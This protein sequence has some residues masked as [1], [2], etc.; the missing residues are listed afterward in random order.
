MLQRVAAIVI[1]PSCLVGALFMRGVG[2]QGLLAAWILS[3]AMVMI[4]LL[5]PRSRMFG[6]SLVQSAPQP[7]VALTFDDGPHPVDTPAILEILE[8][9]GA[10]ATFFF[11]GER[12]RRF[13]ELVR[14]VAQSGHQ[15]EAHSDTH[16][17][18]FSLAS[19]SRTRREV[20]D[21]VGTLSEYSGQR[22][23]FFRPPMGHKSLSLAEVLREEGLQMVVWSVRPFDTVRR[24]ANGIRESVLSKV[25]PGGILLLHEGTGRGQGEPSRTVQ[26]LAPMLKG[27]RERG[28]EPVRLQDL[29]GSEP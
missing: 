20:R 19:A 4:G 23:R 18:W 15:I 7:R 10:K 17:W 11:V 22:P 27:L 12:A 29:L 14:R 13:P 21:S 25:R 6:R 9:A 3:S 26:A 5:R 28:L 2:Q 8:K 16:P 24:S 1:P